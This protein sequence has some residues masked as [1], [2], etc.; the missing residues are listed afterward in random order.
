MS[1]QFQLCS[2]LKYL[3][4]SHFNTKNVKDM[5]FMFNKCNNLN[6][7]KGFNKLNIKNVQNKESILYK[8]PI[9]ESLDL[10][11]FKVKGAN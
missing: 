7:I 10:S 6:E 1:T 9:S 4:L 11:N 8:C 5:S 2:S 3:D